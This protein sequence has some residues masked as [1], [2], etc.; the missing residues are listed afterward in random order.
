[1]RANDF[2]PKASE[3]RRATRGKTRRGRPLN[4]QVKK[5]IASLVSSSQRQEYGIDEAGLGSAPQAS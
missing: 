2:F 5:L 4:K 3:K 1:M